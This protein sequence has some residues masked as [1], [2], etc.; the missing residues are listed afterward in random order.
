MDLNTL[1]KPDRIPWRM[2]G[3]FHNPLCIQVERMDKL[4]RQ[5]S[6]HGCMHHIPTGSKEGKIV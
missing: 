3:C 2:H 6:M 5:S 4:L 1:G